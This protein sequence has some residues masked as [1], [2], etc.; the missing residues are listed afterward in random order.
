MIT[1]FTLAQHGDSVERTWASTLTK[2]FPLYE[3]FWT[4][5]VVPLTYR[6]VDPSSIYLRAAI[7]KELDLMATASYG[8]FAHLAGCHQQLQGDPALFAAEGLYTFYSRLYSAGQS[9]QKFLAAVRKVLVEYNGPAFGGK[10]LPQ[11]LDTNGSTGLYSRFDEAFETRTK[12]YR[13][14]Q[15]HDWGF[16]CLDGKVPRREYMAAWEGKGLGALDTFLKGAASEDEISEHFVDAV[17][18]ARDDLEFVE[19]VINEIWDMVLR[20]LRLIADKE[21]YISDQKQGIEDPPP[22]QKVTGSAVL[23]SP[24]IISGGVVTF[25]DDD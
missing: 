22:K 16:P 10:Q 15:V 8:T 14:Q 13:G 24:E 12:D 18:Q 6:V 23:K 2:N 7:R 19:K 9:V 3:V 20:E 1:A 5:H 21:R 17:E 25:E 11:R 4:E